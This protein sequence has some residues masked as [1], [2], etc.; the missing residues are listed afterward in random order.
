MYGVENIFFRY[1]VVSLVKYK[2]KKEENL[3]SK[4]FTHVHLIME[5]P[6]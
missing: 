3:N 2:K 5:L 6:T 1:F 4:F